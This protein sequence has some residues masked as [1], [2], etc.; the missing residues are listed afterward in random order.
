LLNAYTTTFTL[1]S[2]GKIVN[3]TDKMRGIRVDS[4][5]PSGDAA[6]R[7]AAGI[8]LVE[9]ARRQEMSTR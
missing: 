8:E 1:L 5:C 7:P 3:G 6:V 4:D 2:R 9:P